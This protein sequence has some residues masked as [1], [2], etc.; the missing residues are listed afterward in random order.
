MKG[1]V[2]DG[3]T[4]RGGSIDL[5]ESLGTRGEHKGVP[6]LGTGWR[7][8]EQVLGIQAGRSSSLD[9]RT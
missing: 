6:G 9:S 2:S 7:W 8:Q 3:F 1:R 5:N 4:F